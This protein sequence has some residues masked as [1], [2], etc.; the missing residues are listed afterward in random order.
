MRTG[1]RR[2]PVRPTLGGATMATVTEVRTESSG[3]APV[4]ER[5]AFRGPIQRVLVRPEIGALVGTTAIW[6]FFWAVG[7]VFGTA[8]GTQN[9]L[10]V[11]AGLGIMAVAVSLLMI[12]GEFDLSSGAMTGA[13]AMLV[14]MLSKAVGEFGGAGLS[15]YLAV[16]L[17]LA[18]ALTIGWFNGTIVEKTRLPSFIVTLGTFFVLIGAKL[19][20]SKMFAGQVVVEGLDKAKGYDFW[21]KVFASSWIRND[22]IWN[23]RDVVWTILVIAGVALIAAGVLEMSYRR[24]GPRNPQ[25]LLALGLGA[26]GGLGGLAGLPHRGGATKNFVNGASLGVGVIVAV[27]GWGAWRFPPIGRRGPVQVSRSA[28]KLIAIGVVLVVASVM[29]AAAFNPDSTNAVGILVSDG[30]SR[31]LF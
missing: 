2:S 9:Y 6:V 5:I 30:F 1:E 17:S 3:A 22:H 31:G 25:A 11:A 23:D 15:L 27:L 8:A 24:A 14:I 29:L 28:A 20:F 13:T 4:D 26:V 7:G 21:R 10:D 18:F 19:G 12:G 16:P